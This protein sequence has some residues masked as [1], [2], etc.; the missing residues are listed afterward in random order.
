MSKKLGVA[1]L[2]VLSIYLE[3]T[4]LEKHYASLKLLS[5]GAVDI[6]SQQYV[7]RDC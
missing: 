5:P 3:K 7:A 2:N 4:L 1:F 6:I